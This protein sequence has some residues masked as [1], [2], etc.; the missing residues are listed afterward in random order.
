MANFLFHDWNS[1]SWLSELILSWFEFLSV[2]SG[3]CY[4]SGKSWC[5]WCVLLLL[6][7]LALCCKNNR[8]CWCS[9][10]IPG[11]L[12]NSKRVRRS[13]RVTRLWKDY[14]FCIWWFICGLA[15]SLD[16]FEHFVIVTTSQNTMICQIL[17]LHIRIGNEV[18]IEW[19]SY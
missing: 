3:G 14:Q 1:S 7:L 16:F 18:I 15:T 10:N 19:W 13:L 9:S 4:D 11:N 8:V 2:A 6:T 12:A 17:L 5:I